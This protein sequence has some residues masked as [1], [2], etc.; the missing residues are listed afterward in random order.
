MPATT[1]GG[2][3][4]LNVPSSTNDF[5]DLYGTY[6]VP[7]ME[8]IN[9]N[10]A[11]KG[12]AQTFT[13][14]QTFSTTLTVTAG[15]A[16][17][18]GD[19][20]VSSGS[21]TGVTLKAAGLTGAT[22][23]SRY[24]GATTSG[25]PS[26]GTFSVGDYVID[27]SGAI[28]VCTT[29]GS[30]GTWTAIGNVTYGTP[31]SSAVG[32]SAAAGSATTSARSDHRHGR[33]AFGSPTSLTF[34]G[35]STDGTSSS[36]ARA[37]HVHGLGAAVTSVTAGNGISISGTTTPTITASIAAGTGIS[38]SGTT[39]LSVSATGVQSL[40]AGAGISVSGTT[41]PTVTNSGVTSIVAGTNVTVSG[42]TGAVTVNAPGFATPGSSAIGDTAAAGTATT[43]SRSDHVH[44]REAAGTPGASAVGD[45]ASAGVAT[46][47][48]RSDHRHSR[49]AFG[50]TITA[51]TIG[52]TAAAGTS[53]SVAREDH[54]HAFPAGAAPSALTVSST[55][56]TGT[57]TSPALADHVH[58]MPGSGTPGASA[59]GDT[60]SAGTATTLALSDHRHSREAFGTPVNIDAS[61]TS[62]SAGSLTTVARADHV[63]TVSKVPV[64]IASTTLA[65]DAASYT[66]TS[67]PQTYTHLELGVYAKSNFAFPNDYMACQFNGDTGS[68]YYWNP[69]NNATASTNGNVANITGTTNLETNPTYNRSFIAGYTS[70]NTKSA[71]NSFGFLNVS[72][73]IHDHEW[74][75]GFTYW[76]GTAAI[77]SIKVF[78]GNGTLIKAGAILSLYG[79]P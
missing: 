43:V 23:V 29:G 41:T 11:H 53:T 78:P 25:A 31:G 60:A 38:I 69:Y 57:S 71:Y 64:L 14:A 76:T 1:T 52:G 8:T 22:Q 72:A 67:I 16:N 48:A 28:H 47:V 74:Y 50:T 54:K 75:S 36:P 19:V 12:V 15:G 24:V 39:T 49:E 33:E 55:Q 42:A 18:G 46:T 32:D 10:A 34:G 3:F 56:A 62:L 27:Q 13:A 5:A 4:D 6:L 66:F 35:S 59:V 44:G 17:I 45:T 9:D 7:N 70:S 21:V 63:H 61:I 77:S 2:P 68:N 30:P 26:T 20:V 58:A 65:S 73:S 79:I 40:T 51:S 37:D